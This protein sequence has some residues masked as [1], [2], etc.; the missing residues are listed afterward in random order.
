MPQG[1]AAVEVA[2]DAAGLHRGGGGLGQRGGQRQ[3]A[4]CPAAC[5]IFSAAR[6][7]LRGPSPGSRASRPI[8]RSIGCGRASGQPARRQPPPRQGRQNGSFRPPGRPGRFSPPVAF[9]ISSAMMRLDLLLG[10]GMGGDQQVLQHLDVGRVG[11]LGVDRDAL[12]VALA[13]QRDVDHAGAG[14]GLRPRWLPAWPASPPCWS[15][16]AAP[17]SSVAQVLHGVG[18]S[19]VVRGWNIVVVGR[20]VQVGG[21]FH[22]GN[23]ARLGFRLIVGRRRR[24]H[25]AAEPIGIGG[26][27][28]HRL[29]A[30]AGEGAED[31]LHQRVAL[32]RG[33]AAGLRRAA[34]L[35]ERRLALGVLSAMVQRAPV[36]SC[37]R[38]RRVA[39]PGRAA[40][41][42]R[43]ADLDDRPGAK[44]TRWTVC[45][46]C[47]CSIGFAA[48]ASATTSR[49][50]AGSACA[51]RG[52]RPGRARRRRPRH[53]A[54]AP[55]PSPAAG[56]GGAAAGAAPR[57]R[58][59][60]AA[61][62][63][64]PGVGRSATWPGGSAPSR[65]RRGG[66]ARVS[67]SPRPFSSICQARPSTGTDSFSASA[68]PRVRSASGRRDRPQGRHAVQP[69]QRVGQVQQVLQHHRRGRRRAHA[70]GRS[71]PAPPRRR[72][73]SPPRT[74][75][76]PRRG[77]PG[78]ACRAPLAAVTVAAARAR[79][80]L[81]EQRQAVAHRAVGGAGD[82][83]QRLRLDRHLL[84]GGDAGEMRRAARS[85][86]SGAGRS[87][88]SATA[89]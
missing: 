67:T 43:R 5:S 42:A 11:E 35:G 72:R 51:R 82:Q 29:D 85:L 59:R 75:R 60:S 53:G 68:A 38:A 21:Q 79:D 41:R 74:G 61:C 24:H 33:A 34:L 19:F 62:T 16:S 3:H 66:R 47:A 69:G 2:A 22:G 70:P 81:V 86:A 44:R 76:T 45:T 65:P 57:R 40:R 88:G 37:S 18:L 10:V 46:R 31:G 36:A 48:G 87:A 50:D 7:A 84:R 78:P 80:R 17:A 1:S 12:Q 52:A 83:G 14:A 4:R 28:A 6:R 26:L 30:G 9:C 89:P 15:A 54:A 32:R 64:S 77:R 39:P 73:P 71:S 49:Q 63:R 25:P 27:V 13:G 8:R 56:R 23:V 20:F 55:P 58:P